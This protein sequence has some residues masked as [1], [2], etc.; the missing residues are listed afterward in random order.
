M[1]T[2]NV[3]G[4]KDKKEIVEHYIRCSNIQVKKE[5]IEFLIN[6]KFYNYHTD[7]SNRLG[8]FISNPKSRK[9]DYIRAVGLHEKID[10]KDIYT[11]GDGYNDIDM[12]ES[13][14]GYAMENANNAV[15]QVSLGQYKSVA[16]LADN[17][18]KGK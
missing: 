18:R 2:L 15:K 17:L 12:I 8:V 1:D 5:L 14:N 7:N 3:Y 11:I 6:N 10:D 4:E 13:F 16:D 9:S